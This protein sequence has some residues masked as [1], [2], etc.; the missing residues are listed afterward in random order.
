MHGVCFLPEVVSKFKTLK[1]R[2]VIISLGLNLEKVS[3]DFAFLISL[4]PLPSLSVWLL[5]ERG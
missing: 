1:S 5:L 2:P 3:E 4:L